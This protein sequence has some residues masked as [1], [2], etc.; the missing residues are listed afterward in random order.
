MALA[1][2]Q[3]Q[4][5]VAL[6]VAVPYI[7]VVLSMGYTRQA[8]ALGLICWALLAIQDRRSWL[9][10]IL[11]VV[12][13]TFHKSAVVAMPL[14]LFTL[15]RIKFRHWMLLAAMLSVV[16]AVLVVETFESQWI[17]YVESKERAMVH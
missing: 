9:F 3:A 2:R 16:V 8:A 4:P 12:A 6:A 1:R 15:Q 10:L 17:S 13:A 7:L 11:I 14:Y 5:W